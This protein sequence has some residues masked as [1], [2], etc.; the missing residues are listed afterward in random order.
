MEAFYLD[1]LNNRWLILFLILSQLKAFCGRDYRIFFCLYEL[2]HNVEGFFFKDSSITHRKL[3]FL[4]Y[5][6]SGGLKKK[7][8]M[9][10]EP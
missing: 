8:Q 7:N 9:N 3:A 10:K 5:D 2:S 1:K 6:V 4:F